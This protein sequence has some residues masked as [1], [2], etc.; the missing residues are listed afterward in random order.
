MPIARRMWLL[1]EPMHAVTY[2]APESVDAFKR[3]G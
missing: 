3:A 2:F 1:F